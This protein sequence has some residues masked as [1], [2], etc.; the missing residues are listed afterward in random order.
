MSAV[1]GTFGTVIPM[2]ASTDRSPW[3]RATTHAGGLVEHVRYGTKRVKSVQAAKDHGHLVYLGRRSPEHLFFVLGL[4]HTRWLHGVE[5]TI[6]R[7]V[8]AGDK[9]TFGPTH[10]ISLGP[11]RL[12]FKLRGHMPEFFVWVARRQ[13][14]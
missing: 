3:S 9:M 8:R 2:A 13:P 4:H 6:Q 14:R 11:V 5:L 10:K 7:P 1:V 12:T